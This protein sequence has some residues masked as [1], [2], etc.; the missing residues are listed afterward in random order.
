[1]NSST[2]SSIFLGS[3]PQLNPN[4]STLNPSKSAITLFASAP[5]NNL[6]SSENATV[7]IIG[8]SHTSFAAITAAFNS[9]VSDMVSIAIRSAPASTPASTIS[10]N[11]STASSNSKSPIG[12][13]SLPK[14]PISRATNFSLSFFTFSLAICAFLT[15]AFII[16]LKS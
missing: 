5:F 16:S 8:K 3:N 11:I 9:Y 7:A 12:F 4:T 14:G 2:K 13:K 10:L 1:M 15:A 6:L